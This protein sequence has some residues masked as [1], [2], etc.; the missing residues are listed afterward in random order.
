MMNGGLL[1]KNSKN[2]GKVKTIKRI[3]PADHK[4]RRKAFPKTKIGKWVR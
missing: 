3:R 2:F 4:K 1:K